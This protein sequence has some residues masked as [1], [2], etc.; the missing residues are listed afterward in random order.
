MEKLKTTATSE[1]DTTSTTP[2]SVTGGY[3]QEVSSDVAGLHDIATDQT[4]TPQTKKIAEEVIKVVKEGGQYRALLESLQKA[5]NET[6]T[7]VENYKGGLQQVN[8]WLI[9]VVLFVAVTFV[10]TTIMVY[11][12]KIVSG[13]SDKE[14]YLQYNQLYKQYS[15]A[16][17]EQQLRV[18][19][20]QHSIEMLRAKN[21][22]LK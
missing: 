17:S 13:A 19:D 9:G 16:I 18:S 7:Q 12:D 6:K 11:W 14:L 8:G 4:V 5:G 15:D 10:S 2:E 1:G 22:G 21:P 20:L 3:S